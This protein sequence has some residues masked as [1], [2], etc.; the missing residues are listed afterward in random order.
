[1]GWGSGGP[2]LPTQLLCCESG[3]LVGAPISWQW[4]VT[5][6]QGGRGWVGPQPSGGGG[7]LCWPLEGPRRFLDKAHGALAWMGEAL[8]GPQGKR[9]RPGCGGAS[10]GHGRDWFCCGNPLAPPRWLKKQHIIHIY[11]TRS[12]GP[13]SPQS[14]PGRGN[15][16]ASPEREERACPSP[17]LPAHPP[18]GLRRALH[19]YRV[20]E[21]TVG[22]PRPLPE[23]VAGVRSGCLRGLTGRSRHTGLWRRTCSRGRRA[24]RRGPG[25]VPC[26]QCSTQP[27]RGAALSAAPQL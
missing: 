8:K 22:L 12:T 19:R 13:K 11:Q 10:P 1:M 26:G 17:S 3:V 27:G 2:G 9:K 15:L 6:E 21:G 20:E 24:Q 16:L 4:Q 7:A 25:T 5:L 18:G 14:Q 23:A